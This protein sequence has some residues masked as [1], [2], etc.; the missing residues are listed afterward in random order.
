M[1]WI[2]AVLLF[3]FLFW[4]IDINKFIEALYLADLSVYIPLAI[5]FILIWFLVES[6]NLTKLFQ[7]FGHEITYTEMLPIRG[8][9]YLLMIINYGLG[10]GGIAYYVKK[11][12]GI[13]LL[14][15]SS[16]MIYYTL[17]ESI[18]LSFLAIIGCLLATDSSG[19][20]DKLL[21]ICTALFS[22]YILGF[23]LYRY[24]PEKGLL[25]KLKN[26]ALLKAF[27]E[28]TFMNCLMLFFWR[29]LYFITF[30]LFFYFAVRSFHMDIPMLSL[31]AYVPIIFFLG[32]IPVT[33]LGLGTI[34]AGMLY[35]FKDYGSDANILAFSIVYSATLLLLRAPLGIYYLKKYGE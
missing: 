27:N 34:Q 5:A 11:S 4:K 25:K 15:S 29:G 17:I 28:A 30:I 7:Y 21:I 3:I 26:N 23:V 9:T 18:S 31:A 10:V 14:H 22:G 32:N 13:P 24:L 16:L 1:P 20:T 35:F 2:A 12:S 19:I 8:L 33:P 6:Q